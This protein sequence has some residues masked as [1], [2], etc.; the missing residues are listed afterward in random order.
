MEERYKANSG[1]IDHMIDCQFINPLALGTV[2]FFFRWFWADR[3]SL[4]P[5]TYRISIVLKQS[6][7]NHA[8]LNYFDKKYN[9]VECNHFILSLG[10]E[11]IR[12]SI[13]TGHHV[14]GIK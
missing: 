13:A 1:L 7:T 2:F 8:N 10:K 14:K 5:T 12:V 6:Q 9:F 4:C 11:F 3:S